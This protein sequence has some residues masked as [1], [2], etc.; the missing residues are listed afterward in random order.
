MNITITYIVIERFKVQHQVVTHEQP[1][2]YVEH[3]KSCNGCH[4]GCESY[5]EI[6]PL[7]VRHDH[8]A[9]NDDASPRCYHIPETFH[10]C[11]TAHT[12]ESVSVGANSIGERENFDIRGSTSS[13]INSPESGIESN[14]EVMRTL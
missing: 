12:E 6:Q 3:H 7:P 13:K 5:S 8:I 14:P 9:G 11:C 1:V 4:L 10:D 2:V